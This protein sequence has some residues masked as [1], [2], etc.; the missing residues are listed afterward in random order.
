MEVQVFTAHIST[1]VGGA[2][3]ISILDAD[4]S[5]LAEVVQ[6]IKLQDERKVRELAAMADDLLFGGRGSE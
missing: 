4:D 2:T 5:H 3:L 6:L 1:E